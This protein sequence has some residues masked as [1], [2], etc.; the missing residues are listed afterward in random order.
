MKFVTF[1][2]IASVT[3]AGVESP[4]TATGTL[5]F[6]WNDFMNCPDFTDS[7]NVVEYLI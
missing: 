3:Q 5:N 2:A 4:S 6:L 7:A 1:A